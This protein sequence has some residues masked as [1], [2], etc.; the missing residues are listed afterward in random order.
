MKNSKYIL[1]GMSAFCLVLITATSIKSSFLMPLRTGV[2]FVLVPLQS[3]VNAIGTGLYN[4]LENFSS[5]REA[6]EENKNLQMRLYQLDQEYMQYKKIAARVI[7]KDSGNWF[8]VFRIDKGADDGIQEDMNV[9]AGGGLVGI[10]TDVGANYA[11]VRAIIDDDSNVSGMSLRTGDT[12]NVSGN[13]T[14]Y[15][16]GRLGLDHIKKEADIQEGDKIVTSNISDIFLPGILIGYASGLTTDANNV[17]KSGTI[18]PVADFDN[19]QEVLVIT[20]LKN[21]DG[22]DNNAEAAD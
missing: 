22:G 10:V 2:G 14:L 11:T 18:I 20:Q 16:D 8:Q 19:L 1:A 12:C 5:L 21:G 3:G 9:M 7:A 4:T 17:T 15:Q 6:Q 13:L